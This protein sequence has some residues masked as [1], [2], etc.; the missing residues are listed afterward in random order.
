MPHGALI[1]YLRHPSP[2]WASHTNFCIIVSLTLPVPKFLGVWDRFG[3]IHS[4]AGNSKSTPNEVYALGSP[5]ILKGGNS[6]FPPLVRLVLYHVMLSFMNIC[7]SMIVVTLPHN[8]LLSPLSPCLQVITRW[9]K[10]TH[11]PRLFL[12]AST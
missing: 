9:A 3:C 4:I 6:I 10:S 11:F 2:T 12:M 5:C 8:L 7:L 1:G